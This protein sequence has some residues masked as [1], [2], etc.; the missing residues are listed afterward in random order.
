[1]TRRKAFVDAT[2]LSPDK[3][4]QFERQPSNTTTNGG[5]SM[6]VV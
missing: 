6:Y 3:H 1:M 2:D 4:V 5:L